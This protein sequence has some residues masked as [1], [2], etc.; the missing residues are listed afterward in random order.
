MFPS[1]G[2]YNDVFLSQTNQRLYNTNAG[3]S[4]TNN[5]NYP[6][7]PMIDQ[8]QILPT[9]IASRRLSLGLSGGQHYDSG[10]DLV[11]GCFNGLDFSN[12]SNFFFQK[13]QQDRGGQHQQLRQPAQNHPNYE[14]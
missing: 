10:T 11:G 13:Q 8:P 3:A 6:S 7:Y 4:S 2:G 1:G 9:V 5:N 12:G 14:L